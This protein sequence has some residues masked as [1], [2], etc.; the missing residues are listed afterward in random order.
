[1]CL[2]FCKKNNN[3]KNK[4]KRKVVVCCLLLLFL[5]S[6]MGTVTTN[7]QRRG[8][9]RKEKTLIRGIER[10]LS[11]SDAIPVGCTS[12]FATLDRMSLAA[13]RLC[14]LKTRKEKTRK[15]K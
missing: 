1:M 8:K 4:K 10:P 5:P 14:L 9:K 12:W 2:F 15:R 6:L 11:A 3:S 7:N 13:S